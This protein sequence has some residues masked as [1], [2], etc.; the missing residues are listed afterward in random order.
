MVYLNCCKDTLLLPVQL[1]HQALSFFSARLIP[2]S[3]SPASSV[4]WEF[5]SQGARF[6]I[7]LL[8]LHEG[9]SSVLLQFIR[10]SRND[11]D[12]DQ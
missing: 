5:S 3:Q 10:I 9:S 12:S 1:V 8:E 4:A 2:A 6:H 11:R 7:S